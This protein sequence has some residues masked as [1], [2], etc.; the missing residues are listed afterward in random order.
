LTTRPGRHA[1][2]LGDGHA[3]ER[4]DLD[5]AWPGWDAG[6]DLVVAAD[7]GAR[8]AERLGIRIDRWVG[9]GDSYPR[10]DVDAL[11]KAGIAVR[12]VPTAKDE[13]DLELAVLEAAQAGATRITILGALGGAR[14]DHEL[15]NISLLGHPGLAGLDVRLLDAA[16]R[17]SVIGA[18]DSAGSPVTAVFDGRAGDLVSL[19]PLGDAVRGI[20]THGLEYPLTDEPLVLG[21]ARGLSNVRTIERSSVTVRDGRLLV[22][23]TP[24]NLDR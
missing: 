17:V 22:V 19:L 21:A 20:T 18:P 11:A 15:A 13:S 10:E 14:L 24:A 12:L 2:V 5:R 1:L 8:L 4:A 7:G 9:D 23:E 6:I 3:P 16:T